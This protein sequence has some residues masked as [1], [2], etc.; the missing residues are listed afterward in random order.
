MAD[1]AATLPEG[2]PGLMGGKADALMAGRE[3][4]MAPLTSW[5]PGERK[6]PGL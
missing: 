5:C 6:A 4:Q 1:M 3:G 2:G